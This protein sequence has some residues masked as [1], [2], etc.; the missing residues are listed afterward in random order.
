MPRHPRVNYPGAMYHIMGRGNNGRP[1]ARDEKDYLSFYSVL[2]QYAELYS[3]KIHAHVLMSN[4]YHI[5]LSTP[6]AN[7]KPQTLTF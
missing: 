2:G 6:L 7:V 1:I 5:L 3:V 4:H